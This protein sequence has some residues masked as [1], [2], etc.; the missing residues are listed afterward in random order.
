MSSVL[1]DSRQIYV[2]SKINALASSTTDRNAVTVFLND[3]I[4]VPSGKVAHVSIVSA[5]IPISVTVGNHLY[6]LVDTSLTSISPF[7]G[8]IPIQVP[9]TYINNYYNYNG[10]SIRVNDR[11]IQQFDVRIT[12]EY[13]LDVS[14]GNATDWSLT[15]Q[16]DILNIKP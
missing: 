11:T 2:N 13:G 3:P 12:D 4:L 14:F 8:K 6:L 10:F 16:V 9:A 7:I 1:F 15:L 5:E